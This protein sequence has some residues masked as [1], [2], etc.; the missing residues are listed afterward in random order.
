MSPVKIIEIVACHEV[1]LYSHALVR[2]QSKGY[3]WLIV[4]AMATIVV[5]STRVQGSMVISII[6]CTVLY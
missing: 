3:L 5:D 6:P 1:Q 2:L 4:V